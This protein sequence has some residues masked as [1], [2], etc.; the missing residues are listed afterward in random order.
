MELLLICMMPAGIVLLLFV[1][2]LLYISQSIASAGRKIE[3]H[4]E[5]IKELYMRHSLHESKIARENNALVLQDLKIESEKLKL[6]ELEKRIHPV[7]F[8][9][10]GIDD[11]RPRW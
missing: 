3:L 2:K 5:K 7:R 9:P 6:E 8:N 4:R 1:F 10:E 11:E